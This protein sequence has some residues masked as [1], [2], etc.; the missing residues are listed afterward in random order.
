MWSSWASAR[1]FD[2][3]CHDILMGKLRKCELDEQ[4]VRWI[5][6]RLYGRSLEG[7]DQWYGV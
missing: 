4:M 3:V 1:L 6:D 2:T 5:E 7:C